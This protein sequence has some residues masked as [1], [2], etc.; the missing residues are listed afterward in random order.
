[1]IH[2]HDFICTNRSTRIYRANLDYPQNG[3]VMYTINM[4]VRDIESFGGF[5]YCQVK[6]HFKD[7]I[8]NTH[9][10]NHIHM[11]FTERFNDF[12]F[13]HDSLQPGK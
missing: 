2:L 13:M 6:H 8:I 4:R 12:V 9:D 1:M 7:L 3:V 11:G 10:L 5:V